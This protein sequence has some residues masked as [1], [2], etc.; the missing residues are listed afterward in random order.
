MILEF[1]KTFFAAIASVCS[2]TETKTEKQCETEVLKN[3]KKAEHKNTKQ[4]DLIIDMAKLLY[5]Y[6]NCMS[7]VDKLKLRRYVNRIK[8]VN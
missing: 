4:E 8:G 2:L 7:N 3:K 6:R 5:K 1:L